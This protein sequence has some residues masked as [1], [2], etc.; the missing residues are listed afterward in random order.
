MDRRKWTDQQ[1]IDACKNNK[2]KAEVI[3][4]LG[5]V[6][7]PGNYSTINKYIH[8]LNIDISH[9]KQPGNKKFLDTK[10]KSLNDIL[11]ENSHI[12]AADKAVKK[13]LIHKKRGKNCKDL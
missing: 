6:L 7:R 3:R 9:F 13:I 11:I 10:S 12:K 2:T 5:L 8:Q 1:L 4:E